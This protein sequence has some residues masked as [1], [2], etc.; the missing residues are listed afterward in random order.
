MNPGVLKLEMED[1]IRNAIKE[2]DAATKLTVSSIRIDQRYEGDAPLTVYTEVE[3][4]LE[5]V[6][7]FG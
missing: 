1:T 6:I 2:F 7:G 3:L 4:P 5:P